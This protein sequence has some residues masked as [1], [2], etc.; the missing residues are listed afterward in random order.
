MNFRIGKISPMLVKTFFIFLLSLIIYS[1]PGYCKIMSE[2][3]SK[4]TKAPKTRSPITIV[5]IGDSTVANYDT[6][7][8]TR[9]GWGQLLPTLMYDEVTIINR[10]IPGRS[11]KSFI[12]E[13]AWRRVLDETRPN[14]VFIQFGHND[15]LSKPEDRRTDPG[16]PLDDSTYYFRNNLHTF[17][18][19][20]RRIGAIPVL[21][22]PMERR[23]FN[24]IGLIRQTNQPYA[25][26]M[27]IVAREDDIHLID[28][29]S[30]SVWL[31]EDF[32]QTCGATAGIELHFDNGTPERDRTHFNESGALRYARKVLEEI[33]PL[34][35]L[36]R[37]R[38]F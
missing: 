15:L 22:T 28:L 4:L 26:A 6:R 21:I 3:L 7:S 5:L 25:E 30:F 36:V 14:Y 2:K 8:T 37:Y 27:R 35:E 20:T 38:N 12:E 10:A 18:N 29:Q 33:S 32:Y 34:H 24:S 1:Q 23:Y 16:I 17:I 9:R 11:S 19:D 13:G 31:Y